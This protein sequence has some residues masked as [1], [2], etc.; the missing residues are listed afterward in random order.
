MMF[1]TKIKPRKTANEYKILHVIHFL[2]FN[3]GFAFVSQFD[4]C[5]TFFLCHWVV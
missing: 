2:I 1:I 3:V 5:L 4:C